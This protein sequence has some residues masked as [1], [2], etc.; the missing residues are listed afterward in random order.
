M[1]LT[2]GGEEPFYRPD[3]YDKPVDRSKGKSMAFKALSRSEVNK[4]KG[5]QDCFQND[6]NRY[7]VKYFDPKVHGNVKFDQPR[8]KKKGPPP[9][10]IDDRSIRK[11]AEIALDVR[12]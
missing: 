9:R 11:L 12:R 8:M 4:L 5:S 2:R 10:N 7:R 1:A 3:P 6:F